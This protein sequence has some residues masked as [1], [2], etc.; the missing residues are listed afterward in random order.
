MSA[1]YRTLLIDGNNLLIRSQKAAE[2]GRLALST[3]DGIP[4]AAL[5][6]FINTLSRYLRE[7]VPERMVVCWDGGRSQYRASIFE[8]YKASRSSRTGR[9]EPQGIFGLAK[10]FLTL[11]G[12]HHVELPGVEADDLIAAYWQHR[13]ADERL[14]ILSGDKDFLQLLNGWTEQIRPG[15]GLSERWTANRVR[16][17]MGCRPEQLPLVMAL[18]GDAGDGVPGIPGF[19]YKTA[20][21]FLARYGWSL[22]TLLEAGEKRL[23]GQ[24]E[25]VLRN[26]RLVDLRTPREDVPVVPEP[27]VFRPTEIT[28]AAGKSFLDFLMRYQ[29]ASVRDR[30]VA[31]A[32][33]RKVGSDRGEVRRLQV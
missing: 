28:D 26:L 17:E 29:L 25:A 24:R 32:L 19:G 1:E 2:G 27:P 10:E 31:G 14:V 22:E 6:I 13:R 21:K 33:W 8:G 7:I 23:F 4:T 15:G 5:L 9:D 3:D 16:T 18:T 11:A 20:C 12:I 30:F